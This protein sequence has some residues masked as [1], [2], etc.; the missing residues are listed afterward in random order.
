MVSLSH[1]VMF[2]LLS[3]FVLSGLD[4]VS[5]DIRA[6]RLWILRR[7]GR[8]PFGRLPT[9]EQLREVPEEGI[10]ILVPL[11]HEWRVIEAMVET[12]L[13]QVD[14]SNYRFFLGV[15]LNDGE[16]KAAAQ[17]LAAMH[18][19]VH[20]VECPYPGPTSKADCLNHLYAGLQRFQTS[21][22][23]RHRLVML[24][25]AEDV[26]HPQSLRLVNWYSATYGMIQVPVLS[27]KV[28]WN[29]WVSGVYCDEFAEFLSRDLPVRAVE[30]AFLPSNGVGTAIRLEELET[31]RLRRNGM[32]F[33]PECLT[34][35][36]E[37]GLRLHQDKCRQLLLPLS[38]EYGQLLATM[39]CFP[40]TIRG[41]VRQRTRWVVGQGLQSWQMNGW[42]LRW[43]LLY[44]FWRDR[45]GLVGN[46]LNA[47]ALG[48]LVVSL[49]AWIAPGIAL[50]NPWTWF[51]GSASGARWIYGACAFFAL[52]RLLVR[53]AIV[54]SVYGWA[55]A[56]GVPLRMAVSCGINLVATTEAFRRFTVANLKRKRLRWLKTDHIFPDALVHEASGE[57]AIAASVTAS[58]TGNLTLPSRTAYSTTTADLRQQ[59]GAMSQ[60]VDYGRQPPLP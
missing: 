52:Q 16:T 41:A 21:R 35:D 54:G 49:V 4:D 55:F 19:R 40:G 39:E 18:P 32:L 31:L 38:R 9:V 23:I 14:Y 57:A 43:D 8:S 10:A 50:P 58:S 45:R 24:H 12:N 36:Y 60:E 27:V 33:D 15:Y 42:P 20:V 51:S 47:I 37:L 13:R 22:S 5:M 7:I 26:I 56:L 30:G 17:K 1:L 48:L 29:A 59:R 34:E 25:D 3:Y 11:W 44:W 53:M 6:L 28:P 2:Y 46:F